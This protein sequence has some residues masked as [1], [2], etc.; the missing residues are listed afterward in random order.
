MQ[1]KEQRRKSKQKKKQVS[2]IYKLLQDKY[3]Y[4][5]YVYMHRV[6]HTNTQHASSQTRALDFCS[7]SIPF[8]FFSSSMWMCAQAIFLNAL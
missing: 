3:I 2:S 1:N 7:I 6:T 8:W 5:L 4:I